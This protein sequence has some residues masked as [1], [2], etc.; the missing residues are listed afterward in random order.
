MAEQLSNYIASTTVAVG[1]YTSGSGVLNVLST[2]GN[3]P[4]HP[5]FTVI[6]QDFANNPVVL[7]RVTGINS[8]TQFAVTAEG[9]DANA[10]AGFAV[11]SVLSSA[12]LRQ[13]F[14]D[15]IRINV[16]SF[17]AT[18]TFDFSLG[19][20]QQITLT[21]NV[22]SSTATNIVAGKQ[23]TFM[24]IQDAVGN[25]SLVWPT[26][27]KGGITVSLGNANQYCMQN[28]LSPD[29]VTLY[30]TGRGEFI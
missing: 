10:L 30:A 5:T 28:F 21:G 13:L 22:T 26:N 17:S 16:V 9:P 4:T 18:P 29:G 3:F 8:S 7:L 20:T 15:Q 23:V 11:Y 2:T 24:I 1:G 12:A 19:T 25:R 14:A 6:V 27:V